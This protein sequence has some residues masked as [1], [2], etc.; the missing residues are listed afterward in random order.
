M[1]KLV[2]VAFALVAAG[3]L[4][5]TPAM[6]QEKKERSAAPRAPAVKIDKKDGRPVSTKSLASRTALCRAD[7]SPKK[8]DSK[9]GVGIHGIY[10]RF[11]EF[12]PNLQSIEGK[13]SYA[14]C[15][16]LC[17]A[18]LPAIYVQ[19]AVFAMGAQSWFGAPKASCLNC[20]VKGH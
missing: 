4:A 19:R 16:D 12:D 5:L 17:L 2:L 10:R 13:K 9:T 14:Q 18:P 20:H 1:K 15:V 7:C 6:T 11:N 3:T 8:Y